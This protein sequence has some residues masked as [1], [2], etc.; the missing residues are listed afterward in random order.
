[1]KSFLPILSA[2]ILIG[3]PAIAQEK[4]EAPKAAVAAPK[5]DKPADITLNAPVKKWVDAEN[6]MIKP[7]SPR[8]KESIFI[9]RNKYSTIKVIGIV[10]GEIGAAVKACGK[11]N[12]D[13][14]DTMDTRFGQWKT[15]VMPIIET[16]DKLLQK[17]IDAQKTV[18]PK[19]FRRVMKLSDEAYEYN[20][21]QVVKQ[22]V[23][24]KEACQGLLDSMDST[25]NDMIARLE[26]TLLPESVIRERSAAIERANKAQK[27]AAEKPAA[28]AAPKKEPAKNA[29]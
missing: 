13:L 20:N 16:A 9:L 29:E 28:E 7:L 15:N 2:L 19:E 11:K 8:E 1:M 18:A 23:T 4:A 12:P 25:E 24:T 22:V 21:K 10:E 17:D 6:A 5:A 14:K 26:Q 3:A 27:K